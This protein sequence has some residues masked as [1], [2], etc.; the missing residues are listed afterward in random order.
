MTSLLNRRTRSRPGTALSAVEN[1]DGLPVSTSV[2]L[3]EPKPFPLS[4]V[5]LEPDVLE[6]YSDPDSPA[7]KPPPKKK[8]PR[9]QDVIE[10]S[11]SPDEQ[12]AEELANLP[13]QPGDSEY[14]GPKTKKSRINTLQAVR[15][16][17][18]PVTRRRAKMSGT[19]V[20]EP[21]PQIISRPKG[22][23][24]SSPRLK[25]K[26][27]NTSPQIDPDLKKAMMTTFRD[28]DLTPHP[29][30]PRALPPFSPIFPKT[31]PPPSPPDYD[32]VPPASVAIRSWIDQTKTRDPVLQRPLNADKEQLSEKGRRVLFKD[33]NPFIDN[34][35][36][37]SSD[38]VR[39]E[40]N[41]A[42]NNRYDSGDSF[43]N[44][45]DSD[46]E[47][48]DSLSVAGASEEEW[49]GIML[50]DDLEADTP[51]DHGK[52]SSKYGLFTP[53]TPPPNF[54]LHDSSPVTP[55]PD[56]G[57]GRARLREEPRDVQYE[58]DLRTAIDRS[59]IEHIRPL[60][61]PYQ[62]AQSLTP[63]ASSSRV[64]LSS[65][66]LT[67]SM[68]TPNTPGASMP[69][70]SP[71]VQ[72]PST[73]SPSGP[74]PKVPASAPVT[75]V[76]STKTTSTT[77]SD[78]TLSHH[79]LAL[80]S[81]DE[82]NNV[83][84]QDVLLMNNYNH[85][86]PLRVGVIHPLTE[87]T[88]AGFPPFSMWKEGFDGIN[89][90]SVFNAVRFIDVPN[91][92][93]INPCRASPVRVDCKEI[94]SG[95]KYTL[96]RQGGPLVAVVCGL[97]ESSQLTHFGTGPLKTKNIRVNLPSQESQRYASWNCMVF[98][99]KPLFSHLWRNAYQYSTRPAPKD[100]DSKSSFQSRF[101]SGPSSGFGTDT[102]VA[103][104]NSYSLAHT[105]D[106]PVYDARNARTVD[107][108]VD[109]PK[110][111]EFLP[112][113]DGEIPYGSL[114]VVGHSLSCYITSSGKYS[115]KW[116]LGCN[117]LWAIVLGTPSNPE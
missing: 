81:A 78:P 51:N 10:L 39:S 102:G 44:D 95:T 61:R 105:A 106:V 109:L 20:L 107:F 34:E 112:P 69:T 98:G 38:S 74:L 85:T 75:P 111:A 8:R 6:V 19:K 89:W 42:V 99:K 72:T 80:P 31:P 27:S 113:F 100:N 36:E 115:A 62:P 59:K 4:V 94:S 101:V 16:G 91:G 103:G 29:A 77:S 86:P 22:R 14:Q 53:S 50:S 52:A 88:T 64:Q 71:S 15:E 32:A 58:N 28:P 63:S 5:E 110:L 66:R 23:K 92:P 60:D 104:P 79:V 41:D 83:A 11:D 45:H 30:S 49:G 25:K 54:P 1:S 93:Y 55:R 76:P 47:S 18:P 97:L 56:K 117:I 70:P 13:L 116:T 114:V 37:A 35:A 12:T 73:P 26:A 84:L 40:D 67:S 48:S 33:S 17:S 82:V 96:M 24:R 87:S 21:S 108:N 7:G 90:D 2:T 9:P 46:H 3:R 57:K 43:I 65:G 68:L